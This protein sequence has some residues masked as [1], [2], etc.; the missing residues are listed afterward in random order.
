MGIYVNCYLLQV[1]KIRRMRIILL[2]AIKRYG[3]AIKQYGPGLVTYVTWKRKRV[4]GIG[5]VGKRRN[6]IF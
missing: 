1:L 5:S 2:S 3:S 6:E 4:R